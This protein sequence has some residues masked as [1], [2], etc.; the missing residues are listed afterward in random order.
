[1][2]PYDQNEIENDINNMSIDTTVDLQSKINSMVNKYN[3]ISTSDTFKN[4]HDI[5]SNS[6]SDMES[7]DNE[8]LSHA[9]HRAAVDAELTN[10]AELGMEKDTDSDKSR[11]DTMGLAQFTGLLSKI[12]S[13]YTAHDGNAPSVSVNNENVGVS[14][15]L[16]VSS[17][18]S[19]SNRASGT[20]SSSVSESVSNVIGYASGMATT[21]SNIW[22]NTTDASDEA[23]IHAVSV[24]KDEVL[25]T[26]SSVGASIVHTFKKTNLKDLSEEEPNEVLQ[27]ENGYNYNKTNISKI[28]ILGDSVLSMRQMMHIQ[29]KWIG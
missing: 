17:T 5:D 2:D 12:S 16:P 25:N 15:T 14:Q 21:V 20:G 6:D 19:A 13:V 4:N 28:S 10:A 3:N 7:D 8:T 22:H 29:V 9:L 18:S 11:S 1:M 24:V 26:L 27:N 23:N